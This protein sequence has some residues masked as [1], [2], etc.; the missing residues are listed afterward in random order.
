[1]S[2]PSEG[3]LIPFVKIKDDWLEAIQF[4]DLVDCLKAVSFEKE[5]WNSPTGK[6]HIGISAE[7]SIAETFKETLPQ[8]K[9]YH[10]LQER[11][12]HH[13]VDELRIFYS[14]VIE[15]EEL[16]DFGV[17]EISADKPR[18]IVRRHPYSLVYPI[19]GIRDHWLDV[20]SKQENFDKEST[21]P[22][23]LY[24]LELQYFFEVQQLFLKGIDFP[25]SE[26]NPVFHFYKTHGPQ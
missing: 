1:M 23:R 10:R 4:I 17:I 24:E 16:M 25:N 5:G 6:N 26:T 8:Q 7:Y 14:D 12:K 2:N 15:D 22:K 3:L 20:E 13:G 18:I 11:M 21:E 19:K 9:N